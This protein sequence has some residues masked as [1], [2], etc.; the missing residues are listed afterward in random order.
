MASKICSTAPSSNTDNVLCG[1][2]LLKKR[3]QL[4]KKEKMQN[5]VILV[6]FSEKIYFQKHE[7]HYLLN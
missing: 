4:D 1:R 7:S 3:Q 5:Y 2:S 6:F